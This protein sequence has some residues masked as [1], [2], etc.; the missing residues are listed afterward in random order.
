MAEQGRVRK[1]VDIFADMM[2]RLEGVNKVCLQL[3]NSDELADFL[4]AI[5]MTKGSL[6][7]LQAAEVERAESVKAREEMVIG[8]DEIA[9]EPVPTITEEQEQKRWRK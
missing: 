1:E 4:S 7:S 3:E 2:D 5:D 9:A 8:V 6:L